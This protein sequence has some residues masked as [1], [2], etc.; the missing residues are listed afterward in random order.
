MRACFRRSHTASS[1]DC[2]LKAARAP[3]PCRRRRS[4]NHYL[5]FDA[6]CRGGSDWPLGHFTARHLGNRH[7]GK[8]SQASSVAPRDTSRARRFLAN[9]AI[10]ASPRT[11]IL[12]SV[13]LRNIRQRRRNHSHYPE[14][15]IPLSRGVHTVGESARHCG[16]FAGRSQILTLVTCYPFYLHWGRAQTVH[17]SRNPPHVEAAYPFHDPTVIV[18]SLAV[19]AFT[20]LPRPAQASGTGKS[21]GRT[22]N[23]GTAQAASSALSQPHFEVLR[24]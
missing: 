17:R 9:P 6:I 22:D 3:Q 1:I 15:R 8:F 10:S 5:E 21:G 18:S 11:A 24:F 12:S 16:A 4:P 13:R 2:W 14:R 23:T 7:R 20:P 19:D